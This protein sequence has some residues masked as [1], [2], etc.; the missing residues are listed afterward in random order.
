MNFGDWHSRLLWKNKKEKEDAY[1]DWKN[2]H[3]PF[4]WLAEFYEIISKGGFDVVI[5]NPPYVE[6]GTV[7]NEY[8]IKDI[9]C[10]S[11]GNLYA[12]V[13][14][15]FLALTNLVNN[16]LINGMIPKLNKKIEQNILKKLFQNNSELQNYF[17][18]TGEHILYY[19][20]AP[21]Y[22]IRAHSFTPY[23]WNEKDGGKISDHNKKLIFSNETDRDLKETNYKATGKVIYDEFYPKKSKSII[24]EIDKILAKHYGFTDEEL[25]FIINYDIKYRMGSE[26]EGE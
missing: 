26:L 9:Q 12:Y 16:N 18:N 10:I 23:F 21:Q 4:H 2:R 8:T 7:K 19:H 25:D 5:G 20:N 3:R 15:R 13:I 17:N 22:F 1:Q 24:D 14:E 11:V 6:Y